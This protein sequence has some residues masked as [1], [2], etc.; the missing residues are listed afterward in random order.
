MPNNLIFCGVYVV[1]SKR[2]CI[3]SLTVDGILANLTPV[4]AN[5]LL[6]V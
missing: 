3:N 1:A 6:A 2:M 4:Y 5:S